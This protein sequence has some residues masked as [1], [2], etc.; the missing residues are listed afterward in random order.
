MEKNEVTVHERIQIKI[1]AAL[2]QCRDF[3]ALLLGDKEWSEL[4]TDLSRTMRFTHSP[5]DIKLNTSCVYRGLRLLHLAQ[6]EGI[7]LAKVD[8]LAPVP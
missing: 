1:N 5:V 8:G 6:P 2:E 7:L 3:N 4:E